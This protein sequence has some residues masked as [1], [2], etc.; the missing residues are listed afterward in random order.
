MFCSCPSS[1][2]KIKETGRNGSETSSSAPALSFFLSLSEFYRVLKK[3]LGGSSNLNDVKKML[4]AH[5]EGSTAA[6]K[7]RTKTAPLAPP[8]GCSCTQH[9]GGLLFLTKQTDL[10]TGLDS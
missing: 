6:K 2:V 1:T 7:R 10:E 8:S 9:H 5:Q 4:Q 3:I